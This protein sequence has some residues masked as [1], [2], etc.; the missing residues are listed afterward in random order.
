[1]WC[2]VDYCL[3]LCPFSFG[4]CIVCPTSIY[5]FWWLLLVSSIFYVYLC[6][7]NFANLQLDTNWSRNRVSIDILHYTVTV[8]VGSSIMMI[9]IIDYCVT[10]SSSIS[11]TFR[12]ITSSIIKQYRNT[13]RDEVNQVNDCW[14]PL[15]KYGELGRDTKIVFC[16]GHNAPTLFLNWFLGLKTTELFSTSPCGG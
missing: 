15:K 10:S 3:S 13:G 9:V 12:T 11:A 4:H 16:T 2:F 6:I 8:A 1:V 5:D 14:L 7:L